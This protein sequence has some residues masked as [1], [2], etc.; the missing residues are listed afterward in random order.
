MSTEKLTF[1]L[2]FV[3]AFAASGRPSEAEPRRNAG[4]AGDGEPLGRELGGRPDRLRPTI[5]QAC[6]GGRGAPRPPPP[7]R[8]PS[9]AASSRRRR[10]R[11]SR[12]RRRCRRSPRRPGAMAGSSSRQSSHQRTPSPSRSSP[13]PFRSQST[14]LCRN[15]GA[16]RDHV[17]R[18]RHGGLEFG[19]GRP[20]VRIGGDVR[21]DLLRPGVDPALHLRH[22]P[23][24]EQRR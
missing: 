17:A 7:S 12:R 24:C 16:R 8:A 5:F 20:A 4:A 23:A 6:C 18:G 9:G 21:G 15:S 2:F 1:S 3:S 22:V 10:R 11:C 13:V 14:K 19:H